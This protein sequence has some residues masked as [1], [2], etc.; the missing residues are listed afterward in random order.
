MVLAT[1]DANGAEYDDDGF[2][3][4]VQRALE[5]DWKVEVV[6]WTGS[7]SSNWKKLK[8]TSK[9]GDNLTI[10]SL[11]EFREDLTRDRT[12]ADKAAD[13]WWWRQT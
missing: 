12:P 6:A 8:E 4:Y 2:L 13:C 3:Q 7:M 5:R 10:I 11:D 1:G 9:F